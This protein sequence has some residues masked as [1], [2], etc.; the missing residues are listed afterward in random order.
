MRVFVCFSGEFPAINLYALYFNT[1]SLF[2]LNNNITNTFQIRGLI[3]I[4]D[5]KYLITFDVIENY[6]ENNLKSNI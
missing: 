6:C 1:V 3:A 4:S 2:V 5:L